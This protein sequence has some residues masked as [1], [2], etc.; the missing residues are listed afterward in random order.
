MKAYF[1][2]FFY[3]TLLA[4]TLP[5]SSTVIKAQLACQS[6]KEL[7][8]KLINTS[9]E[10][11]NQACLKSYKDYELILA[12]KRE[13]FKAHFRQAKEKSM[14][15]EAF[16]FG[17]ESLIQKDEALAKTTM[18]QKADELIECSAILE[19]M[20]NKQN[21]PKQKLYAD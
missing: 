1:F 17:F 20:A 6:P 12:D 3:L 13:Y 5:D 10:Q 4:D 11:K 16:L 8:Q 18:M 21:Q 9:L 7:L 14:V 19:V 15:C 2:I